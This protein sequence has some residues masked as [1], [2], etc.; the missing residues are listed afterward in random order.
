MT[1]VCAFAPTEVCA[2][3]PTEV[4]AF[5]PTEVCAFAPRSSACAQ[6][7]KTSR[8]RLGYALICMVALAMASALPTI[9]SAERQV[10]AIAAQVGNEII[11]LSEVLELSAPVEERMRQ[12]GVPAS[13]IATVRKN[14]LDR[15][16]EGKLLSS[17]VGRL[18]LDA[19]REEVDAAISAIASDNN[20]SI[21]QL[22]RSIVSHGLTIE[23]YR[24]KIKSEVERSKVVNAMVRSRIQISDEEIEI[25]YEEQFS[26]QHSGGEE[27]NLLHLMVSAPGERAQSPDAAC[28]IVAETRE[29][30]ESGELTFGEA[31]QQESDMNP[32]RG[33]QLGWMHRNDLAGWMTD[34]TDKMDAGDLSEVIRMP[35][36][37]NLLQVID[38]RPFERI[39]LE[40]AKPQLQNIVFQRKTEEKYTEWLDELRK[41]TYIE[42]KTN[43]GG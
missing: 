43:F 13:E 12:A 21:E 42:R 23:E 35:F 10:E 11:L 4:C 28:Q 32:E 18:E 19:D 39:E 40:D 24:A 31:A 38:R 29:R 26:Q 25:L 34:S 20:L 3:A 14:A 1:E 36:G 6:P 16:I 41:H 8:T 15:L 37:C 9:A 30:I 7:F 17:V 33:G 22:F 27:F 2:F 5:A